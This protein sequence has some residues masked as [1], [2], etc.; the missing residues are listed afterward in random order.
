MYHAR[1]EVTT[2]PML[3]GIIGLITCTVTLDLKTMVHKF[4]NKTIIVFLYNYAVM[5][6]CLT[7][8]CRPRPLHTL[9]KMLKILIST[10]VT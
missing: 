4:S 6:D 7:E 10:Y 2:W 5:Y 8:K 1:K 9:T 3:H